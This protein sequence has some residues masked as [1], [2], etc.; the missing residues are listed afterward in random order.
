MTSHLPN[1][2]QLQR[3]MREVVTHPNGVEA[4]VRSDAACAEIAHAADAVEQVILP[5]R[6]LTSLERLS[7]YANAY[8]ARLLECLREEFPILA[9]TLGEETFDAFAFGY[10]RSY[11]PRSYTL[12]ELGRHFPKFLAE[13]RP[14]MNADNDD[15]SWPDFLID[16]A[17]LERCYSEVFDGP[18]I[19]NQQVLQPADLMAIPPERWPEARLVPAP[20]LRTL[21]LRYPVHEYISAMR[22]SESAPLP[23]P[24]STHLIITRRDYVV[25]RVSVPAAEFKLLANLMAGQPVGA[26]LANAAADDCMDH[27]AKEAQ[28]FKWFEQWTAAAYFIAVEIAPTATAGG[29]QAQW[30]LIG[31]GRP[32]STQRPN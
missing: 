9:K 32:T 8:H 23:D 13:T 30:P 28:I 14:V 22:R 18:G 6:R 10:I 1:L 2:A 27:A 4:G 25:R 3:W 29:G 26:A 7:I 19:E 21:T 11:P 16:L 24:A 31:Q 20:C 5:S 15:T 12:G 17:T